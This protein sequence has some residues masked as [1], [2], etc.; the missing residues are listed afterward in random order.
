MSACISTHRLVAGHTLLEL[1][2]QR[3]GQL[4]QPALG[5]TVGGVA[6]RAA[7]LDAGADRVEDVRLDASLR[8]HEVE[9]HLSAQQHSDQVHVDHGLDGR[10]AERSE[11]PAAAVD[12]S[13]VDPEVDGPQLLLGELAELLH[14][15]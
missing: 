9:R 6:R 10:R 15:R 7:A 4:R 2:D 1:T 14:A 5:R 12:A 11:G 8:L 13:V 3:V